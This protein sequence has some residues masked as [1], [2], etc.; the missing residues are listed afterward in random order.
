[1]L[2]F[3]ILSILDLP[4]LSNKQGFSLVVPPVLLR[5]IYQEANQYS[6]T[7][8]L[9]CETLINPFHFS[10]L[11]VVDGNRRDNSL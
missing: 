7:R 4:D 3:I 8:Q 2:G 11:T 5:V 1:M 9:G 10:F 6:M